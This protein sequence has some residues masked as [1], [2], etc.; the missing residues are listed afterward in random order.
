MTP[1]LLALVALQ[2]LMGTAHA[3]RFAQD[4]QPTQWYEWANSLFSA[5]VTSVEADKSADVISVRVVETF[6]GPAGAAAAALRVP[7]RMWSSCRL[8]RPTVGARVLVALN[9]NG[10]TLLVPLTPGYSELLRRDRGYR[11]PPQES[12]QA[13]SPA[14]APAAEKPFSY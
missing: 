1:R 3:C 8:E 5:D 11:P 2:L 12:P 13:L 7:S 4:A 9:P 14:P 10:D 6:K